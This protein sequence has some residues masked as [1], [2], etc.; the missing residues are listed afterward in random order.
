MLLLF[1][2]LLTETKSTYHKLHKLCDLLCAPCTLHETITT[3]KIMNISIKT[4]YPSVPS[5]ASPNLPPVPTTLSPGN[6]WS[7]VIS[8]H[9]LEFYKILEFSR[10]NC[11]PCLLHIPRPALSGMVLRCRRVLACI[12]SSSLLTAEWYSIDCG[13][14][15]LF[16][17]SAYWQTFE[18]S[19]VFSYYKAAMNIQV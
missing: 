15:G 12:S 16:S 11:T 17:H 9:Y 19:P 5:N 10:R 6:H 4:N 14:R 1:L 13:H 2:Q 8:S 18:K 7:V 3:I